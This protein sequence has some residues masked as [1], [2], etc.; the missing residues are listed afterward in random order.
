MFGKGLAARAEVR[1]SRDERNGDA[2]H[3][4]ELRFRHHRIVL[5]LGSKYPICSDL[6]QKDELPCVCI[7]V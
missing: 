6:M 7:Q 5:I 3:Q 4:R 2:K 1:G